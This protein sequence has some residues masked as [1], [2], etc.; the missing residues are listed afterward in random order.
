MQSFLDRVQVAFGTSRIESKRAVSGKG[1]CRKMALC[2]EMQ[3]LGAHSPEQASP[4]IT[5]EVAAR[6]AV[7]R[8]HQGF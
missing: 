1:L 3:R 7:K 2:R 6:L 8:Q 5:P 4:R